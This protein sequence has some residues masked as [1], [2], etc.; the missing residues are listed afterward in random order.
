MMHRSELTVLDL[1]AAMVMQ[2]SGAALAARPGVPATTA[3]GRRYRTADA[4][5]PHSRCFV[6]GGPARRCGRTVSS[7]PWP[8]S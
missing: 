3:A 1:G 8:A 5:A 7:M 2:P 6:G 4:A